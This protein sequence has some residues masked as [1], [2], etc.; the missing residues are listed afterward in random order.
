MAN[1]Y[2]VT[3]NTLLGNATITGNLDVDTGQNFPIH[4]GENGTSATIGW[5]MNEALAA[6]NAGFTLYG[7]RMP[8]GG[9][10]LTVVRQVVGG[11]QKSFGVVLCE[12]LQ[13]GSTVNTGNT[14]ENTIYQST[15]RAGLMDLRGLLKLR[16]YFNTTVQGATAST[17]RVYFGATV[18]NS[19]VITASGIRQYDADIQA[20][21]LPN[22]QAMGICLQTH[23]AV[24]QMALITTAVDTTVDQVLKITCQNGSSTDSHQFYFAHALAVHGAVPF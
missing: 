16:F 19:P 1:S 6:I 14:T 2:S 11:A 13:L 15:V 18:F 8:A 24:P 7:F 4:I 12:M 17:I 22:S 10:V 21:G 9:G 20:L 23:A 3:P 5:N